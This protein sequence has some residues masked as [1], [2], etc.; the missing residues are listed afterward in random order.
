MLVNADVVGLYPPHST[1]L[2]SL[3]KAFE[4]IVKNQIPPID[5][6]KMAEFVLCNN[7]SEFSEKVFQ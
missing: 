7:Y 6:V 3:K 1:G 5:L 4:N 2:T